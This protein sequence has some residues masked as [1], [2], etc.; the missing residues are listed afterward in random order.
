MTAAHPSAADAN[1]MA[2]QDGAMRAFGPKP[3]SLSRR[4]VSGCWGAAVVNLAATINGND[5]VVTR[6]RDMEQS[7]RN[8]ARQV[9]T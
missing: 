9:G 3:K 7:Q 5:G 4:E 2:L 8:V 1:K 6:S